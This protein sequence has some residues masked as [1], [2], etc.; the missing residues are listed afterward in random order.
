MRYTSACPPKML[1]KKIKNQTV[2]IKSVTSPLIAGPQWRAISRAIKKLRNVDAVRAT[3]VF[4]IS[5]C[6]KMFNKAN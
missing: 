6:T 3:T 1:L 4:S 2:V 5:L